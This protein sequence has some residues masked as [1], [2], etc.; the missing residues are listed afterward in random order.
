MASKVQRTSFMTTTTSF[1]TFYSQETLED[2]HRSQALQ[3]HRLLQNLLLARQLHSSHQDRAQG[4]G[5]PHQGQHQQPRGGH[6]P[7]L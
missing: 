3:V 7:R 2:P 4:H 1:I 6:G 5:R